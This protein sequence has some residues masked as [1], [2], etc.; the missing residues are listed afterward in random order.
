MYRG[1]FRSSVSPPSG[2]F[3]EPTGGWP[4]FGSSIQQQGYDH[5]AGRHA[6]RFRRQDEQGVGACQGVQDT[7]SLFACRGGEEL[8]V[9]HLGM[10]ADIF[11]AARRM[12]HVL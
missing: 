3:Q 8:S 7:R 4:L 11:T 1:D 5:L 10:S 2:R 9:T 6:W 12:D